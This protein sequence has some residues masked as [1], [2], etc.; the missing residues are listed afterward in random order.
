MTILLTGATGHLGRHVLDA[1]LERGVAPTDLVAGGRRLDALAEYAARGVRVV[2]L[3]Y[4][5]PETVAAAVD[6]VDTV[7]LISA[8]EPGKRLPQHQAVIDAA[9][10]A[11]VG[12]IVY[13]SILHA[14]DTPHV[15]APEHKATEQAIAASGI[16]ATLLRNGWYTEN[17]ASTLDAARGTGEI[18]ASAGDGRVASASRRDY[19]EAAAAVLTT[20]G[21][22]GEVYE[23]SGDVAWTHADLAAALAEVLGRDVAYRDVA[24][25]EHTAT[26]IA[27]GLDAGTAGFVVAMDQNTKAGLLASTTGDLSRLIGRPTTPLKDALATLA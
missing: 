22:E 2:E 9:A 14:A 4:D 16:P 7:L 17:Y 27:L 23:L 25:E 19:A 24:P 20:E 13:T 3:D 10:A 5:R 6:G 26:L 1:L 21:H 18:V 15:L 11:G 8:S 12:R